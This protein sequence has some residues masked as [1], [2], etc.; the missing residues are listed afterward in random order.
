[1]IFA[2]LFECRLLRASVSYFDAMIVIAVCCR[3]L[4]LNAPLYFFF[5][6]GGG[7]GAL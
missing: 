6:G 7:G 4:V 1:M 2:T 3:A 5:G